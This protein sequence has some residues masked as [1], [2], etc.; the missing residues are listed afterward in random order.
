MSKETG[1]PWE[2]KRSDV[3]GW[4]T[5]SAMSSSTKH[6][7]NSNSKSSKYRKTGKF[8]DSEREATTK[9]VQRH[10]ERVAP[11][12]PPTHTTATDHSQNKKAPHNANCS[13]HLTARCACHNWASPAAI[14]SD[15]TP[16]IR[17]TS[18]CGRQT[19]YSWLARHCQQFRR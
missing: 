6:G 9:G 1:R 12:S 8:S 7:M 3:G 19:T 2:H 13:I 10:C 16:S 4:R 15:E 11:H 17:R 18:H 14:H 5:H